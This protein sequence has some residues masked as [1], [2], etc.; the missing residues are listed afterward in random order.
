[1]W[2]PKICYL[3]REL[4]SLNAQILPPGIAPSYLWTALVNA[5]SNSE[6]Y[7]DVV[8]LRNISMAVHQSYCQNLT[9]EDN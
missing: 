9:S 7:G 2:I 5:D 8:M 1:M 4:S 3:D 6:S